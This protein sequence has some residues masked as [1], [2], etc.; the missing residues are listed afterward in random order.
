M[1]DEFIGCAGS[2]HGALSSASLGYSSHFLQCLFSQPALPPTC[3]FSNPVGSQHQKRCANLSV[4]LPL[5]PPAPFLLLPSEYSGKK[6]GGLS[7]I[8]KGKK[9][10][11]LPWRM[12][13]LRLNTWHP[14]FSNH[15]MHKQKKDIF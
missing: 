7:T 5:A 15:K 12:K 2:E 8:Q 3:L 9:F 1:S 13:R 10:P 14:D 11:I 6:V 4:S